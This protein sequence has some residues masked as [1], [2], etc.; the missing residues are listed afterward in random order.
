MGTFHVFCFCTFCIF[1]SLSFCVGF[2]FVYYSGIVLSPFF[3][4]PVIVCAFRFVSFACDGRVGFCV[5]YARFCLVFLSFL[6]CGFC[7]MRLCWFFPVSDF[8]NMRLCWSL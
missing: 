7:G 2:F 1:P 4:F 6:R 5:F 3:V 8:V